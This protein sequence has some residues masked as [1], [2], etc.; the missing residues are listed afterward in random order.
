M[1]YYSMRFYTLS[2]YNVSLS[3]YRVRCF[4]Y[5]LRSYA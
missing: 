5:S 3:I 2:Y 1:R 4:V